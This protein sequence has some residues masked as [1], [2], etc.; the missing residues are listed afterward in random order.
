[1]SDETENALTVPE[2]SL[3]AETVTETSNILAVLDQALPPVQAAEIMEEMVPSYDNMPFVILVQSQSP[4]TL[5]PH[6]VGAGK[7]ILRKSK[8]EFAELGESVDVLVIDWRAKAMRV[9]KTTNRIEVEYD[10][11]SEKFLEIQESAKA[12]A[13]GCFWCFEFL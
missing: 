4:Y 6:R 12:K 13:Q 11:N 3:P 1:M 9:D 5:P 10:R 8:N 7:F 2:E